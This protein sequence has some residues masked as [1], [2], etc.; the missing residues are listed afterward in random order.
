M[1]TK[2]STCNKESPLEGAFVNAMIAV[3]WQ[4]AGLGLVTPSCAAYDNVRPSPMTLLSRPTSRGAAEYNNACV[5]T[6]AVRK[7]VT[8]PR[9]QGHVPGAVC[10][11]KQTGVCSMLFK[12][13]FTAICCVAVLA[14]CAAGMTSNPA[15]PQDIYSQT[16]VSHDPHT[17]TIH[18]NGPLVF[19]ED[20]LV[21]GD[22]YS[23][24]VN[25]K[26]GKITT[27][28]FFAARFKEWAYLE[29]AYSEGKPYTLQKINSEVERCGA[30]SCT[31]TEAVGIP[32][33]LQQ[34]RQLAKK[35][36][37]SIKLSGRTGSKVFTI[38]GTYFQG[39]LQK[40]DETKK[41]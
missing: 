30:K 15:S 9:H 20:G 13:I 25:E 17:K 40:Y 7:T 12:N 33:S 34:M 39:V 35:E 38:P 14:G 26:G 6:L 8:T 37:F 32:L 5:N 11:T 36:V 27:G 22:G 28:L 41:K 10:V 16:K 21:L 23:A 18:V 1:S 4:I 24:F 31:L 29:K 19:V 2:I 3:D